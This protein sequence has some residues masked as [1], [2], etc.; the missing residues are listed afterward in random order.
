VVGKGTS[1]PGLRRIGH[2][3][4]SKSARGR[5]TKGKAGKDGSEKSR[6]KTIARRAER[7]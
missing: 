6:D 7:Q 2:R 4:K 3:G 5:E 1:R